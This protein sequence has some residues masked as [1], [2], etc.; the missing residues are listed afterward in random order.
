MMKI[1]C[2][3][4]INKLM[5]QW[6]RPIGHSKRSLHVGALGNACDDGHKLDGFA[7]ACALHGRTIVGGVVR[8]LHQLVDKVISCL[9]SFS[10]L[11]LMGYL[12]CYKKR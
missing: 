5:R 4:S 12:L 1:G 6:H 3:A 2:Q 7:G 10:C 9:H 11:L 8:A